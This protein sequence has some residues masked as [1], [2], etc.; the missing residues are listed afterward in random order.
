MAG[1]QWFRFTSDEKAPKLV[2]LSLDS[3]DR[4][5]PSDVDVF[6]RDRDELTPYREGASPYTPEAT[7]NFPGLMKFRTCIVKPGETYYVRVAANHPAW[8]LRTERYDVPPYRNAQQA[9]QAGMNYLVRLGDAWHANTP[10]RRCGPSK[11]HAACGNSELYRVP[12]HAVHRPWVFDGREE[13]IPAD[14]A[15]SH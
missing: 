5:V 13:R 10:A 3:A 4:D 7:Q 8:Q 2:Y 1:V 6:R 12:C 9:V 14:G 11:H 15:P